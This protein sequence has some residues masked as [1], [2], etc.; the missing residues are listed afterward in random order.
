MMEA[1][2]T[3]S[4]LAFEPLTAVVGDRITWGLRPEG[5]PL[6]GVTF[7]IASN[8]RLYT[9]KARLQA[10]RPLVQM[11]AWGGTPDEAKTVRDLILAW[12]DATKTAPLQLFVENDHDSSEAGDG[13]QPVTQTIDT[14]RASLDVRVWH[15]PAA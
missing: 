11:D 4:A 5:D 12:T 13:P 9:L 15:S 7:S 2:L 14:F 8:P 3:A 10:T 6:P 1:D